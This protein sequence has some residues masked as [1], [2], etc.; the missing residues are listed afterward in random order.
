VIIGLSVM[1]MIVVFVLIILKAK[2]ESADV[3]KYRAKVHERV[4]QL[5]D[6]P[7]GC[8]QFLEDLLHD[9]SQPPDVIREVLVRE[10]AQQRIVSF[11]QGAEDTKRALYYYNLAARLPS[12]NGQ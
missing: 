8:A 10:M 2:N 6:D 4:V 11:A 3:D 12:C 1:A 5:R 9:Q 7:V